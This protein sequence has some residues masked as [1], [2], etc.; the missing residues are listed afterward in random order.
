MFGSLQDIIRQFADC[1]AKTLI[2][3]PVIGFRKHLE[4]LAQISHFHANRQYAAHVLLDSKCHT[5]DYAKLKLQI[6][7]STNDPSDSLKNLVAQF[8]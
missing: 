4:N 1:F 5:N 8:I 3:N 2:L 6:A 7:P